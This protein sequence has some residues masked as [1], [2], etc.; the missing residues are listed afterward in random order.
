MRKRPGPCASGAFSL[1]GCA[2]GCWSGWSRQAAFGQEQPVGIRLR[3]ANTTSQQ[4]PAERLYGRAH[5][6]HAV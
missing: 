3:V 4:A 6:A 5:P 2:D 1:A